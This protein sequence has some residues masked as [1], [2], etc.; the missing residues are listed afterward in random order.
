MHDFRRRRRPHQLRHP[1]HA[2]ALLVDGGTYNGVTVSGI[3]FTKAARIHWEA[4]NLLGPASDFVDHADA[5]DAACSALIG[6][7]L[8]ELDTQSPTGTVSADVVNSGDCA[9]V[10]AAA[11]VELRT[12]PTFCNFQ[13]LL[14]PNAPALCGGSA[15][16]DIHFQDFDS[17]LV[18]WAVGTRAVV[19]PATFDTPDW[20]VVGNLPDRSGS[21]AF[22]EDGL[23]GD[24]QTDIEA[25]VLYLQSP[26]ITF[27]PA[28]RS[29]SLSTTGSPPSSTG[30]APTSGRASTAAPTR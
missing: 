9:E 1:Q 23:R 16:S 29:S 3:G 30:T 8:Y 18:G 10:A 25:G 24:C 21:A 4:Q 14:D 7:T 12:E 26:V 11:A 17:G 27:W 2:Y 15:T 5:L 13:P 28:L 20:A 22:V 6:A 19:N